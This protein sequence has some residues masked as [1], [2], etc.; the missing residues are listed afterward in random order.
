MSSL[1]IQIFFYGAL[2]SWF[3]DVNFNFNLKLVY[4]S[5]FYLWKKNEDLLMVSSTSVL[6]KQ[7]LKKGEK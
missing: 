2:L 6:I 7:K 3:S 5:V 1:E 4:L